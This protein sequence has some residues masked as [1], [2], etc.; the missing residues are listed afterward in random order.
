MSARFAHEHV[1]LR[2]TMLEKGALDRNRHTLDN[3]AQHLLGL[4]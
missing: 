1:A 3:L 2:M 4:L